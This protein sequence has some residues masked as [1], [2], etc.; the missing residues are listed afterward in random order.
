M[1]KFT[2]MIYAWVQFDPSRLNLQR[3]VEFKI[4]TKVNESETLGFF[5]DYLN[6]AEPESWF[7]LTQKNITVYKM[8][9]GQLKHIS[10]FC[11]YNLIFVYTI[12]H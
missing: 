10:I 1:F 12:P 3:K 9:R 2:S 7:K 5:A 11:L 8:C 6:N 4:A